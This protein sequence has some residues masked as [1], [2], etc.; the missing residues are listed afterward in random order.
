MADTSKAPTHTAF[1]LK[2]EGKKYGKWLEIGKAR[3]D[4]NGVIHLFLDRTPIGG[5]NG[6]AYLAPIGAEPP[7]FDPEPQRPAGTVDD[8]E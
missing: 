1:A 4:A 3:Q 8:M 5:F 7:V 2:R 6:Y